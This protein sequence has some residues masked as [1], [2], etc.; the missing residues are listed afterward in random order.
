[1]TIGAFFAGLG[2]AVVTGVKMV[3]AAIAGAS[4][5]TVVNVAVGV[6]VV[7]ATAVATVKYFSDRKKVYGGT[8]GNTKPVSPVQYGLAKDYADP[9]NQ[10]ELDELT[11]KSV[12]GPLRGSMSKKDV[13]KLINK[14]NSSKKKNNCRA[15]T[16]KVKSV[17]KSKK[18][19]AEILDDLTRDLEVQKFG[20]EFI[21]RV[22]DYHGVDSLNIENFNY[23]D[24]VLDP[25]ADIQHCL[26]LFEEDRK[27][28]S[29]YDQYDDVERKKTELRRAWNPDL[30]D[31]YDGDELSVDPLWQDT[32]LDKFNELGEYIGLDD[33]ATYDPDFELYEDL[34]IQ[35][36]VKEAMEATQN[37]VEPESYYV[38]EEGTLWDL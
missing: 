17:K 34:D 31:Q 11:L 3:G 24:A 8:C 18:Y 35:Q 10:A 21:D 27:L 12:A 7:A 30:N 19:Y 13:K 15:N 14:I 16:K 2:K 4:L 28:M 23:A 22:K 9:R 6:T 25:N 36:K 1:M 20:S 29:A 37:L 32:V 33:D 38:R 5:G 26:K